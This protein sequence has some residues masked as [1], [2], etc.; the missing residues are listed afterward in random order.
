MTSPSWASW[1]KAEETAAVRKF[2]SPFG[3]VPLA[4]A[5]KA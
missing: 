5:T 2:F 3:Q 1:A 4:V